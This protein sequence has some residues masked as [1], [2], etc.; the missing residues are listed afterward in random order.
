MEPT[1]FRCPVVY[2]NVLTGSAETYTLD[3]LPIGVDDVKQGN[4]YFQLHPLR[5]F[6][7]ENINDGNVKWVLIES[8]QNRQLI[9]P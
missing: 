8:F 9:N 4:Y 7:C 6:Y 1:M 5:Y 2:T 3:Q